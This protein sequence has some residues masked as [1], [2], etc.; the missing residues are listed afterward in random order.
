[1]GE[2]NCPFQKSDVYS[3][4]DGEIYN[5]NEVLELFKYGSKTFSELLIDAYKNKQLET[6]LSKIDGC[7]TAILYDK[8]EVKLISDRYG[9]KPLYIWNNE[10]SFAWVSEVK[11]LLALECFKPEINT[12]AI[13]CFMD[14][15]HLLGDI[16]WFKDVK[17]INAA[18]IITYSLK[19]RE[20]L[21]EN[22]YWKWSD[23]KP[24]TLSLNEAA[25]KL[26]SLLQ[27][28]VQK[29]AK[30]GEKIG[31]SL[32]GGL[33]S[34][35]VLAAVNRNDGQNV[36]Y[37]TF[38]K[39]G[40]DDIKIASK[41]T[42]IKNNPHYVF[43]LNEKN[44][45]NERFH[46]VWKTDGMISLLHLHNPESYE[47]L[48]E[49]FDININGF[50]GDLSMGGS[51]IDDLEKKINK[52]AAS[53][54]FGN[55][56]EYTDLNNSF[57]NISHQDPYFIDTRVRR[58]TNVGLIRYSFNIETR[59][60]FIDNDLIEF[61]Y[62]LPDKY[63]YK[64]KLFK[65]TLLYYYPEYF[66]NIP[67]QKTGYPIS[68]EM[69][70]PRRLILTIKKLLD[71]FPIIKTK[72]NFTNYSSWLR[73]PSIVKLTKKILDPKHAIYSNYLNINFIDKYI[74]PHND[75]KANSINIGFNFLRFLI[76]SIK[77]YVRK[78]FHTS[79]TPFM[80]ILNNIA[81][82]YSH[83]YAEEICRALTMEIWFQ[84]VFNKKYRN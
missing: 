78:R 72:R 43:E 13:K 44:W 1:M 64:S 51:W 81:L 53:K 77:E 4:I 38:G 32:S 79:N 27:N 7:F 49:L 9:M 54:K 69:T 17:M 39:K 59:R 26:S 37:F 75:L 20:L 8:N 35:S 3:W 47:Y 74:E 12:K 50:I 21:E 83:D 29:R 2:K 23:I 25:I 67:W 46:S 19:Q 70:L 40:C 82:K 68:K 63:R 28:A 24:Q 48:R 73:N 16:T 14:L 58:F 30:I 76:Y 22:R 57:Y 6:V 15:G 80:T 52:S 60:P 65:K 41:V 71:K 10:D 33:D 62:S 34:R 45:M 84:Q 18:S 11:A 5:L 66:E 42:S 56:I 36:I 55:H 31:V 61:L